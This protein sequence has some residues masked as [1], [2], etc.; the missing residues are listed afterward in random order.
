[1]GYSLA[2]L[3][4]FTLQLSVMLNAGV[5]LP[6]ALETLTQMEGGMQPVTQQLLRQ[7]E[8]GHPL[9]SAMER[10]P[11]AFPPTYRRVIRVGESTGQLLL[12]LPSLSDSLSQQ[13]RTRQRFLGSLTY[14]LFVLGVSA[15]M[16]SF[17]LF[18]QLPRL[19]SVF[20]EGA[21][22]PWLTRLVL[23]SIKPLG[24]TMAL[25]VIATLAGLLA[26]R[27]FPGVQE[28]LLRRLPRVP[29][30]GPLLA[31]F[32]LV[33]LCRDLS[34]MLQHGLELSRSLR[35]FIEGGSGWPDLDDRV[36]G[37]LDDIL[38]GEELNQA[39]A[40]QR[41]PKLLVALVRCNEELGHIEQGFAH[42]AEMGENRL[43][44]AS[45]DFLRLLEPA[46][47]LFMGF[48]VGTLV[49]A[50]FLPVYQQLQS[51]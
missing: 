5:S 28:A 8:G 36:R 12:V 46:L 6:R 11:W 4:L 18:F 21:Q 9:S 25:G 22:L 14:P 31:D 32:F 50:C 1:M 48:V 17:L 38:R 29:K 43:E 47:H 23:A 24:A 16:V 41:F 35:T 34:L 37:V 49:I 33:Q 39:L 44:A 40:H 20:G 26:L 42:Y 2:D 45:E 3:Q 30:L 13:L 7:I 27:R 19:L 15:L 10:L 51:L